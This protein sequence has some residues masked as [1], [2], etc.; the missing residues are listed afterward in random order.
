MDLRQIARELTD[1][2]DYQH[3]DNDLS[4]P[5]IWEENIWSVTPLV[6]EM[7]FILASLLLFYANA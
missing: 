4:Y 3:C 7:T 1:R 2:T 6:A 5:W